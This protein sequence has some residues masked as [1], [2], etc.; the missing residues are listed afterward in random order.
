MTRLKE[1]LRRSVHDRPHPCK[2]ADSGAAGFEVGGSFQLERGTQ[3]SYLEA[4]MSQLH[5]I[6]GRR[7]SK[8]RGRKS[9]CWIRRHAQGAVHFPDSSHAWANGKGGDVA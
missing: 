1:P 8:F 2:L 3:R 5:Q 9:Q 7:L 4:R 6:N